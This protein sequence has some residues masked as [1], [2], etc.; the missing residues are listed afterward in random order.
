MKNLA[1]ATHVLFSASRGNVCLHKMIE[2]T[3]FSFNKLFRVTAYVLKFIE[4]L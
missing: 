2:C 3:R 1:A 4:S